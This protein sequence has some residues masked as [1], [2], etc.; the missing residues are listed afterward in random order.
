VSA[1]ALPVASQLPRWDASNI[2][3]P[4]WCLSLCQKNSTF[5]QSQKQSCLRT[6]PYGQRA[7]TIILANPTGSTGCN[8]PW[9]L[10]LCQ[11]LQRHWSAYQRYLHVVGQPQRKL[12][13]CEC[14]VKIPSLRPPTLFSWH[15]MLGE[16]EHPY[17]LCHQRQHMLWCAG[18][19]TEVELKWNAAH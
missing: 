19:S 18:V 14:A 2:H 16:Q 7:F 1:I 11:L 13:G 15:G 5:G 12:E 3:S 6:P 8:L 10:G 17:L 9:Q 4:L